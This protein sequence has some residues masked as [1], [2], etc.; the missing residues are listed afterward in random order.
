MRRI[1]IGYETKLLSQ[2]LKKLENNSNHLNS[3]RNRY[4]LHWDGKMLHGL[5]HVKT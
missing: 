1:A 4:L 2:Y 5:E 3:K